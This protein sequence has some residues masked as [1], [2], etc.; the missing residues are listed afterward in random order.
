[1]LTV[2]PTGLVPFYQHAGE[3]VSLWKAGVSVMAILAA[4]AFSC[5]KARK[6]P[7]LI[8]GLAWY[9]I[10]LLP[11][12]GILQVGWHA[13]TNH[14]LVKEGLS[15]HSWYEEDVIDAITD[16][17]HFALNHR[18]LG[19]NVDVQRVL[20]CVQ[21]HLNLERAES[22]CTKQKTGDCAK[23]CKAKKKGR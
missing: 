5:W 12:I 3:Q 22:G 10:M 8:V 13:M 17:M 6:Y 18:Q 7:Y 2:W 4:V 23:K 15:G 9:L 21:T 11:V 14:K 20:R 19:P 1:M 16:I